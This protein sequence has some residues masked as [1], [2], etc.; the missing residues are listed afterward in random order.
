MGQA[1]QFNLKRFFLFAG[2]GLAA[3][4]AAVVLVLANRYTDVV[5]ADQRADHLRPQAAVLA[6]LRYD[7]AQI[8]QYLTDVAATREPAAFVDAAKYYRS[9]QLQLDNLSSMNPDSQPEVDEL[10][11]AL[12]LTYTTGLRMAHAYLE[13]GSEAGNQIM[14]NPT[15]GF[16]WLSDVLGRRTEALYAR[17]N[18]ESRNYEG[19]LD[20]SITWLGRI[21]LIMDAALIVG[22]LGLFWW[23]Y[24]R[25]VQIIGAEPVKAQ[26]LLQQLVNA[27]LKLGAER[28]D[29]KPDIMA[30]TQSI[31]GLIH[32]RET[33]LE[34]ARQATAVAEAANHAK[35][36]F[37]ANMSHEIRTPM[38]GVIGMTELALATD[39][40]PIQ[41]GHL[42]IVRSS[43][44]SLLSVIN[45]ILDFSKIEAGK[46]DIE[47]IPFSLRNTL[48][49]TLMALGH[50]ASEKHL[51]LNCEIAPEI[52]D[53]LIAD[54]GRL[55]QILT[56]LLSNAI[57]FS[58]RGHIKLTALLTD[59]PQQ[60]QFIVEDHGIGIA[61]DKLQHIFESFSQAD[62]STTRRFGGTGLGL[63]ICKQLVEMMGGKIWVESRPGVGSR[64]QFTLPYL[65]G[66]DAPVSSTLLD[67]HLLAD[68]RLLIIEDNLA[69]QRWLTTLL[70]GTGLQ[71]DLADN[72]AAARVLF[73]Q[74]AYQIVLLDIR[75]PDASG[76]DLL[77]WLKQQQ[78]NAAV[79]VATA[80]GTPT[81]AARCH[82]LGARGFLH[83]P[84]SKMELHAALLQCLT[85]IDSTQN[86]RLITRQQLIQAQRP[87]RVL[88]AEDNAVNQILAQALLEQMGHS[89]VIA[90]NG[91]MTVEAFNQ[92]DFDLILMDMHMP[93]MNGMEATQ[94]IRRIEAERGLARIPIIALTANAMAEA[95]TECANAGM[96]G[97]VCKPIK[98]ELLRK[99]IERCIGL[100]LHSEPLQA[101]AS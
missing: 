47:A 10:R 64:F 96:D 29:A 35:S 26:Q 20:N 82:E 101:R 31:E 73:G 15:E 24:R 4:L 7:I 34:N 49:E 63:T 97:Y 68:Q 57:K 36:L 44:E 52:A 17:V 11:V 51:T 19:L 59:E 90:D 9:A 61:A 18:A 41:R 28:N 6:E 40:T 53:C 45:D 80:V 72:A 8:Q 48:R 50:R 89:V 62:S 75:L 70:V 69:D 2:L 33:A 16:D 1:S 22:V 30:L 37:L 99:E 83:K 25:L 67:F 3:V 84:L 42:N 66:A 92:G 27:D 88:V 54:P 87:L 55:R 78:P 86:A 23:V 93:E 43:A 71:I 76:L 14:K 56:N 85:D 60:L 91:V 12:N 79:L 98:S 77:P 39:L 100:P 81:D 13:L 38:N 21:N 95:M 46:L 74:H 5:K 58:E 94:T 32:D 65:V